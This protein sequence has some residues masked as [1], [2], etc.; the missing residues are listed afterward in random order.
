VETIDVLINDYFTYIHPLCPFPHEPSFREAWRRREDYNNRPFLALLAS[1]ISALVASFP[2]KPRLHLKAQR[3][4]NIFPNHMALVDRCQKVC[5]A[6]RGPGYL[7]SET[8]SVHDAATSYLL[9]LTGTYTF[10]WRQGRLYLGE[11][12]TIFK[13]LGLHKAKDNTYQSLGGLPAAFGSEG[14]NHEGSRDEILDNITLQMGR[15]LFWTMFVSS[16]SLAQLGAS[17]GEL[18]IPPETPTDPYPPLPAEVDDFCIFPTHIDPQPLGLMPMM[19]GFNANVRIFLSDQ[20]INIM[21]LAWGVDNVFD[22]DKQRRVFKESAQRCKSAM[23]EL[24]PQL[25]IWATPGNAFSNTEDTKYNDPFA[26]L[27]Q[28][29]TGRDPSIL[30]APDPDTSP[31]DRRNVQYEI[32]KA[33][34]YSSY[35]CNRSYIVEKYFYASEVNSQRNGIGHAGVDQTSSNVVNSRLDNMLPPDQ[36]SPDVTDQEMA[37][38]RENTV[39]DL[40][41]VLS[42]IDRVNMEPNGDSFV[43]ILPLLL[44]RFSHAVFAN[45]TTH[46]VAQNPLRSLDPPRRAQIAQRQRRPAERTVPQDLPRHSRQTRAHGSHQQRS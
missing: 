14:P 32:Q 12:M 22:W 7:E 25:N 26:Q 8:L 20:L 3:K 45:I 21:E 4:E 18:Y 41:F 28:S 19:A 46:P 11:C 5:V 44:S 35:L 24:P 38:E 10:R 6:A 1:M 39:K 30:N 15:R 23:E 42:N 43:R 27:Q 34:I 13:T 40:L 29:L 33:N 9:G 17:F 37:E 31:E 36:D 2:R 16:R